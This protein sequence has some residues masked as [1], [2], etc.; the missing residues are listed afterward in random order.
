[1]ADERSAATDRTGASGAGLPDLV[2]TSPDPVLAGAVDLH[3]HGYPDV[4][5]EWRMRVDDLTMVRLAHDYGLRGL[6]LKSHFWPTM[7]RAL[8]LNERLAAPDFEVFSSITLNHLVGGISP[9]AVEAA[10]LHGARVV[11]FP[12]WG[13]RNDHSRGGVV[14]RDLIDRLLPAFGP[15]LDRTAITVVDGNGRLLPE[16]REVLEV[17]R[18]LSLLVSTAHVSVAE[19]LAIA[20]AGADVGL[21]RLVFAHP[22]SRSVQADAT[23]MKEMADRGA[24]VE[25]THTL[26]V[27]AG[28]PVRVQDVYEA[29]LAL[30]PEHVVLTTDVYFSWQPPQPESMRMFVG[31]LREHGCSDEDLRTMVVTN[32]SRLLGLDAEHSTR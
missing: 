7:D 17:A 29:V 11:F 3:V 25:M 16:A 5:L 28:A 6:V 19:S 1:M 13:S 12:T 26:T 21:D 22:F 24:V 18:D 23:V 31:Q 10:A 9:M 14:R 32:P 27:L 15:R 30:G 8:L 20:T 2:P 4:G